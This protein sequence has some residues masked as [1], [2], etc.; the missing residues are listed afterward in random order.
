MTPA[1]PKVSVITACWNARAY[2]PE[3]YASLAAQS[4]SEWEWIVG[5][6]G[7]DDGSPEYLEELA[8]KDPRVRVLRLPRR[9]LPAPGRNA[10]MA[11]ARGRYMAFLDADDAFLPA[12]L[13]RQAALLE[14]DPTV[15]MT[16]CDVIEFSESDPEGSLAGRA[17]PR[18][19]PRRPVPRRAFDFALEFGNVFCTS[20]IMIRREVY[21]RIGPQDEAAELRAVEDHDYVLRITREFDTV[22][23]DGELARY[24]IH[25]GNITKSIRFEKFRALRTRLEARGHLDTRGARRYLS[26]YHLML[27]E[28]GLLGMEG[29]QP[30]K[31]FVISLLHDPL[32]W[33]RWPPLVVLP[34]PRGPALR[35]YRAMKRLQY[36]IG[37]GFAASH[38]MLVETSE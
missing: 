17:R 7:S 18:A 32:N 14:A 4:L 13:E 26:A 24:R 29:A 21:E 19:W 16:W 5:D 11:A 8:S 20:S 30:R 2:L 12:K 10:A 34:L 37:G 22:K 9:G 36:R 33:R 23:T 1:A 25:E 31:D 15:G 3:T 38:P 35:V 27:A 28:W 6:D